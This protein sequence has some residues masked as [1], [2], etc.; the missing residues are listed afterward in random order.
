M[1]DAFSTS[2]ILLVLL[3]PPAH[4]K[5]HVRTTRDEFKGTRAPPSELNGNF[6]LVAHE[7]GIVAIVGDPCLSLSFSYKAKLNDLMASQKSFSVAIVRRKLADFFIFF[8]R[9]RGKT[10]YGD[11]SWPPFLSCFKN[12]C[13]GVFCETAGCLFGF[14]DLLVILSF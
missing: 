5:C 2:S 11:K 13:A 14:A 7:D 12:L 8:T 9:E 4:S 6:S 1:Q 10:Q 3:S